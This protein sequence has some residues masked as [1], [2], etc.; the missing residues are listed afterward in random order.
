MPYTLATDGACRRNPGPTGW[1]WVG[2]D[3]RWAAGSLA[4][5]TNNVGELLALLNALR[6]H[7]HVE[8][9]VVQADSMYVINTYRT[10]MD[11]H[12]RRGWRTSAGQPVAN[13]GILEA[14]I[15]ARDARRAAS[16]PDIVLEHV[17]GHAGHVLNSWADERAVRASHHGDRGLESQWSSDHG[18]ARL[19][20]TMAPG[21]KEAG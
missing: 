16:L 6:D 13:R 7:A 14:L 9:L 19:D 18:Q 15:A 10:W 2:E 20:V 11:G 4:N 1:A 3:G 17:K 8:E 5:G 21:K 12:A